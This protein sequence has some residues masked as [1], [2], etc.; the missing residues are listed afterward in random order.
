MTRGDNSVTSQHLA[1]P[2]G[3]REWLRAHPAGG[4]RWW[5]SDGS[6]QGRNPTNRGALPR[7]FGGSPSPAAPS[8]GSLHPQSL[9]AARRPPGSCGWSP[10]ARR[11]RC[12]R[13]ALRA[14]T[15][16]PRGAQPAH[17]PPASFP[18]P[19]SPSPHRRG[20]GRALGTAA[21]AQFAPSHRWE[22]LAP[23]LAGAAGSG[24]ARGAPRSC[25]STRT[26]QGTS[27]RCCTGT[28]RAGAW[29]L[30]DKLGGTPMS[31]RG[32]WSWRTSATRSLGLCCG[33]RA[34]A[35]PARP[36]W[37]ALGFWGCPSGLEEH[38]GSPTCRADDHRGWIR[39]LG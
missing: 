9:T 37:W 31:Q 5:P 38:E 28:G 14:P 32:L 29:Q 33:S 26:V 8:L 35:V 18:F 19:I 10:R 2:A 25:A 11:C 13:A 7:G 39:A 20:S 27:V 36:H 6:G 16:A 1:V 4:T 12:P 3:G 30:G 15:P 23:S 24:E 34:E 17:A 22:P 21:A